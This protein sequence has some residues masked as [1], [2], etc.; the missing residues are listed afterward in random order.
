M[1]TCREKVDLGNKFMLFLVVGT[2]HK[3]LNEFKVLLLSFRL[4]FQLEAA[5]EVACCWMNLL[6]T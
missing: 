6:Q 4:L 1:D 5:G 3:T 2:P